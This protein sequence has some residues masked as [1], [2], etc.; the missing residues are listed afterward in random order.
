MPPLGR[1][2]FRGKAQIDWLLPDGWGAAELL[3][4]AGQGGPW[5]PVPRER[6]LWRTDWVLW[7]W[8]LL[9]LLLA[10]WAS[11]PAPRGVAGL[12]GTAGAACLHLLHLRRKSQVTGS[13]W[14]VPWQGEGITW[15]SLCLFEGWFSCQVSFSPGEA[16]SDLTG[17]KP[18]GVTGAPEHPVCV[19]SWGNF[20]LSFF[21]FCQIQTLLKAQGKAFEEMWA[22]SNLSDL[23]VSVYASM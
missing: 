19:W 4:Q 22:T 9:L 5:L 15:L 21:F 16:L 13:G 7:P 3:L 18:W 1:N 17:S 2:A 20:F 12:Q 6:C 8:K 23:M 14:V 10:N 11:L